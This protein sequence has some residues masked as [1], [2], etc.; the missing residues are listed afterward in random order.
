[1]KNARMW[2]ARMLA[3]WLIACLLTPCAAL[4][5]QEDA[6][7][8]AD[9]TAARTASAEETDSTPLPGTAAP[10]T[11]VPETSAPETSAPETAAPTPEV[12]PEEQ[13]ELS[14]VDEGW[15]ARAGETI[16]LALPVTYALGET[17]VCSSEYLWQDEQGTSL[18]DLSYEDYRSGRYPG[19]FTGEIANALQEVEVRLLAGED[20][21]YLFSLRGD[22]SSRP[23]NGSFLSAYALFEGLTI[24]PDATPGAYRLRVEIYYTDRAGHTNRNGEPLRDSVT[25]V[26]EEAQSTP[27][28]TG[29]PTQEPDPTDGPEPTGEPEPTDAPD[30]SQGQLMLGEVRGTPAFQAK[31]TGALA[32][33]VSFVMGTARVYSN[34]DDAGNYVPYGPDA[35]Y[36]E[37]IL[38]Y[39]DYLALEITPEM[40][41][42]LSC[43]LE[44]GEQ[45]VSHVVIGNG[46]NRGYA[47]FEGLKVRSGAGNGVQ[48][49]VLR[50]TYRA[51]GEEELHEAE[52]SLNV[53]VTG[54]S[55]GGG[56]GGGSYVAPTALPQ[57]RLLVEKIATDPQDVTAGQSFELVFTIRNTSARQYVQNIRATI[58][59]QDDALLPLSGSNTVYID[60]IDAD[61]TVELRY[62]VTSSLSVP[63]TAMKVD[64]LFEYEDQAV[65]AQ[66]AS[67]TLNVK[68]AQLQRIKV[69][70]PIT[71][72]MS[73]TEGDSYGISL[74]VIN[75]GRTTLY[76][77]TV[78]ARSDR[79]ELLLPASYYLGN[80]ESGSSKKAELSVTP[81]VSGQYELEL[82]VSYEDGLGKLYTESRPVSFWCEAE[83]TYDYTQDD[84]S[85]GATYDEWE[86]DEGSR[87]MEIL[88][89][90]PWW[91][92]AAAAALV[93]LIVISI[94]VS[95]HSR[96][97]KALEDDEMD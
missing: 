53:N 63:E 27:E 4:A 31:Q 25:L 68:V 55:S 91:I 24:R 65:T 3:A 51:A 9:S 62:P 13:P 69:D 28:P 39:L 77:V 71:D 67:Q 48:P 5:R 47:V 85:G 20:A 42:D 30:P 45:G 75:E 32:V 38:Q 59:V 46:V 16:D 21:A 34:R 23:V 82:E 54:V 50:A 2:C 26:V 35:V 73:P 92:F 37:E 76:N 43:P 88:S 90:M 49:V 86:E 94:G 36:G 22:L 12:T 80:M 17:R 6:G 84:W 64:V 44:M 33:P 19:A 11:P 95:A 79:E 8:Q 10:D 89:L 57:A 70:D 97:V 61:S 58:N 60:R 7:A 93:V 78:T 72:S 15:Q 29:E 52:I 66:S 81:L 56:G 87:A 74:Q 1:M 83:Q 40:A 14:L 41:A 96:H 18:I